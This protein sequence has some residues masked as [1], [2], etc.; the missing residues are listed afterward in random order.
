MKYLLIYFTVIATLSAQSGHLPTEAAEK[1]SGASQIINDTSFDSVLAYQLTGYDKE[2]FETAESLIRIIRQHES[3]P[4]NAFMGPTLKEYSLAKIPIAI[5]KSKNRNV[6]LIFNWDKAPVAGMPLNKEMTKVMGKNVYDLEGIEQKQLTTQ[7]EE[8]GQIR[9]FSY[10]LGS[11]SIPGWQPHKDYLP[12]THPLRVAL[13]VERMTILNPSFDPWLDLLQGQ[14]PLS[15]IFK[16]G[17]K[18][19]LLDTFVHETFHSVEIVAELKEKGQFQPS[20][21]SLFLA[22]KELKN[23]PEAYKYFAAYDKEI[24]A[25]SLLNDPNSQSFQQR[26]S[27]ISWLLKEI[28][29]RYPENFLVLQ[30]LEYAEGGATFAAGAV[31]INEGIQGKN[32]IVKSRIEDEG[33][34]LYY[35]TGSL[36]GHLIYDLGIKF[37]PQVAKEK[38]YWEL[39]AEN[40]MLPSAPDPQMDII[41]RVKADDI[42]Q[43]AELL[44]EYMGTEPASSTD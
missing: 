23:S 41:E 8:N 26:L 18:V 1:Q 12:E 32:A 33:N 37:E 38:T 31:L 36:G 27:N 6:F 39:I 3:R 43:T 10:L 42:K 29:K 11:K 15:A 24:S 2:E 5:P 21:Y 19:S 13:G 34:N 30:G 4:L 16:E 44:G 35:R 22:A 7:R 25:I 14:A 17:A 28:K 9:G 40:Q 20:T